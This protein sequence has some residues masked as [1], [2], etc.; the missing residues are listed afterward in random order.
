[1]WSF[2]PEPTHRIVKWPHGAVGTVAFTPDGKRLVI[3]SHDGAITEWTDDDHHREL[4]A[5]GEPVE[6]VR[7]VPG[8]DRVVIASAGDA[9]W[10]G[11]A[12]GLVRL[13]SEPDRIASAVCS[14]DGRW[15]ALGSVRGA[16]RLY[17]LSTGTSE[18]IVRGEPWIGALSFSPDSRSLGIVTANKVILYPTPGTLG[19]RREIDLAA[20]HLAF[21]PDGAWLAL[22][23]DHGELWFYRRRDD[24]WVYLS[25]G[26]AR[27]PL[28]LFSEDGASFAATDSSGRALLVDMRAHVFD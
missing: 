11:T 1:M 26:T 25:L 2:A 7:V 16:V 20:R 12:T 14:S 10:L 9:L 6:F 8:S 27:I 22:T 18:V 17:D 21:S 24:H 3:G 19:A 4:W 13:G 5:L 23:C 15:L 28:G